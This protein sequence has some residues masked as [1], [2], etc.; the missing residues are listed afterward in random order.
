MSRTKMIL[1]DFNLTLLFLSKTGIVETVFVNQETTQ[2]TKRKSSM[3]PVF[4]QRAEILQVYGGSLY[5]TLTVK[6]I[7]PDAMRWGIKLW[8]I[9]T[10]D[11]I[12]MQSVGK[13]PEGV[14]KKD[15]AQI[16]G[17][18][19]EWLYQLIEKN[20]I[21]EPDK[22]SQGKNKLYSYKVAW[23]ICRLLD[24]PNNHVYER[25]IPD[26]SSEEDLRQY[27]YKKKMKKSRS[28]QSQKFDFSGKKELT[29]KTGPEAH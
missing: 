22:Q 14:T 10:L 5:Q 25:K 29:V 28:F 9:D 24:L 11:R 19:R 2:K 18:S 21:P 17:I 3:E 8:S 4:L 7:P 23:D 16:L 1:T 6:K 13:P 20:V 12:W 27:M 26:F 15:L